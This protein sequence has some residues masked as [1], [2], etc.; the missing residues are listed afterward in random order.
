MGTSLR[1]KFVCEQDIGI[2]ITIHAPYALTVLAR[3][4]FQF[5]PGVDMVVL[6]KRLAL[7]SGKIS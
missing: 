5:A 2:T 7:T 6:Q 3:L 4:A 1:D